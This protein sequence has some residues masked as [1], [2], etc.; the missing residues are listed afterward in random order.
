MILSFYVAVDKAL[1]SLSISLTVHF[2]DVKTWGSAA[3]LSL[4]RKQVVA[5]HTAFEDTKIKMFLF[6]V[7]TSRNQAITDNEVF[8]MHSMFSLAKSSMYFAL[9]GIIPGD[10]MWF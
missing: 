5:N 10:K 9:N 8:S 1:C 7:A 6:R 4:G 2:H 3:I